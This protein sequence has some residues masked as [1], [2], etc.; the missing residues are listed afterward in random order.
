MSRSCFT[1][2]VRRMK[3]CGFVACIVTSYSRPMN[4]RPGFTTVVANCNLPMMDFSS[5]RVTLS[6]VM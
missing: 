6:C 1:D 2:S 3:C 4:G 5:R